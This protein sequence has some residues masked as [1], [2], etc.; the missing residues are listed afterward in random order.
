MKALFS[1]AKYVRKNRKLWV[2][3]I[4]LPAFFSMAANIYF[5]GILQNYIAKVTE[6]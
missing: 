5:A 4:L 2:C 6:H 3:G 1:M